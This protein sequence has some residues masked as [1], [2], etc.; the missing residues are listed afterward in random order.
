MRR[1][2]GAVLGLAVARPLRGVVIV[3]R[4]MEEGVGL[5]TVLS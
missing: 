1:Y 3:G 4:W 2:A 5:N